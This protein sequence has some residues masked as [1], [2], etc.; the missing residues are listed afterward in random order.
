MIMIVFRYA[1]MFNVQY[2]IYNTNRM[3]QS[4]I[5][6]GASRTTEK[7]EV[8]LFVIKITTDSC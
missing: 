5:F 8:E 3:L 6:W 2:T 4:T 1:T 7:P